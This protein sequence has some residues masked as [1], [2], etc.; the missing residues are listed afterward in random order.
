MGNEEGL[1]YKD[2]GVDIEVARETKEEF[3]DFMEKDNERVLNQLGDF[4]SLY[5]VQFSGMENPIL[6]MKSE[7]PG[8]KQLLAARHENYE[9]ICY[10]MI[11]HLINDCIV[12]GARPLMVQDSIIC[13]KIE[14]NVVTTMVK[15]MNDACKEQGCILIGG[16][17]SEQP[18]VVEGGTY[19]LVSS[20]VG[21]VDKDELIDGSDIE[22]GDAIVGVSS[23]G[24]HTNGYSLV[25]KLLEKKPE[26]ENKKIEEETFIEALLR[27][28]LCYYD[29]VKD[30]FEEDVIKGMAHVTGGGI[31]DNLRRILPKNLDANIDLSK[32]RIHDVFKLIKREGNVSE[33][34]MLKTFNMGVGLAVVVPDDEKDY[35][36]SH[37]SEKGPDCYKIGTI[38]GKGGSRVKFSQSLKW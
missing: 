24:L 34:E 10:D 26:L 23:N 25:R 32:Y 12:V 7:E 16:E 3:A 14:K 1:S 22:G 2:A 33:E 6:V 4:A 17:T 38:I 21:I 36:M 30:L 27:P 28:H 5:D 37:I 15:A 11:N 19:I 13:G 18:G 35:V 31:R 29:C 20:V 8:S 9:S